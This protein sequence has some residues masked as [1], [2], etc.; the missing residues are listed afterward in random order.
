MSTL[1]EFDQWLFLL[2]N[3]A[4]T[5]WMDTVMIAITNKLVWIP[6]YVLL[7]VLT[8]REY[9]KGALW[10]CVFVI[11]TITASD[12]L[13]TWG[14]KEVF[15]RLRPCHA[16]DL[17]SSIHLLV[18][19][20]GKYGFVSSHATNAFALAMFLGSVLGRRWPVFRSG[21]MIWAAIVSYSRVYVGKH[22]PLDIFCGAILGLFI[23]WVMIR[24]YRTFIY[25]FVSS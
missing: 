9:K 25:K 2:L 3:G 19:C 7:L 8:I 12:Q 15:Q 24:A 6:L 11:F 13:S 17:A 23:G 4:H 14:F 10:V 16:E 22:Y 5:P 21:L 1:L 18:G 20:G